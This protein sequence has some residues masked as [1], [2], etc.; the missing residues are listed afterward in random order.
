MRVKLHFKNRY[1][2]VN[3]QLVRADVWHLRWMHLGPAYVAQRFL[4]IFHFLFTYSYIHNPSFETTIVD[5]CLFDLWMLWLLWGFG[6]VGN[7]FVLFWHSY[8]WFSRK[9]EAI[10]NARHIITELEKQGEPAKSALSEAQKDLA[11]LEG[12][13]GSPNGE[14]V[15]QLSE[16]MKLQGGDWSHLER[17]GRQSLHK[18]LNCMKPLVHCW[19]G[20]LQHSES[21]EDQA[22]VLPVM[23]VERESR[24]SLSV[25]TVVVFKMSQW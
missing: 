21:N 20:L 12:S 4:F 1:I 13:Q 22:R 24:L 18:L 14:A 17:S 5:V 15:G 2:F 7:I 19:Q 10:A 25:A 23:E 8:V 9:E 16:S 3:A 6:C 11:E